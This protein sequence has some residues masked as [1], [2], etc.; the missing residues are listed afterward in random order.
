MSSWRVADHVDGGADGA[1]GA[2]GASGGGDGGEG[3]GGE[4]DAPRL[5]WHATFD[6]AVEAEMPF[7]VPT[8]WPPPAAVAAGLR[9][10]RCSR[11]L[12]HDQVRA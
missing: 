7:A 10:E 3:G 4:G 1:D 8:L 11:L 2:D 12:H 5:R 9:L 6:R